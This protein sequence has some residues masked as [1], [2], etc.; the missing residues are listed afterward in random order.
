MFAACHPISLT[1]TD[2][3]MNLP[4]RGFF[5]STNDATQIDLIGKRR[6][7]NL[8]GGALGSAAGL[9]HL[10]WE[11]RVEGNFIVCGKELNRLNRR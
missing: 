11:L 7:G 5:D 4:P 1:L 9:A 3:V 2:D 10:Y 8:L 6:L